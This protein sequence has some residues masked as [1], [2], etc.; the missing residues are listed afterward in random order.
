MMQL[1][2]SVS[3]VFIL[4]YQLFR[5]LL[6]EGVFF[7]YLDISFLG[8]FRPRISSKITFRQCVKHAN[9]NGD[10]KNP[11]ASILGIIPLLSVSSTQYKR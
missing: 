7:Q 1:K 9:H 10:R 11:L 8:F 2:V 5:F 4:F 6:G 3:E